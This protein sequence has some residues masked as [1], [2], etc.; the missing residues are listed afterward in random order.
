LVTDLLLRGE[1]LD[2]VWLESVKAHDFARNAKFRHIAESILIMQRFVQNV[3]GQNGGSTAV[4]EDERAFEARLLENPAPTKLCWYWILRLRA[5]F[6]FGDYA[7]AIAAGQQARAL[8]WASEGHIQLLDYCF[9]TALSAAAY[10]KEAPPDK[11]SELRE[12]LIQHLAQLKEWAENCPSTFRD[13]Y[14]LAAAEFARIKGRDL[15]AMRLY[16]EAIQSAHE[17]GFIHNEGIACEIAAKFCLQQGFNSIAN[18]YVRQARSCYLRWGA[19]SKVK[20]LDQLYPGLKELEPPGPTITI[21]ASIEQLDLATVVKAMQAVS[22]EI[23]LGKLIET[24]MVIA[25]QCAG[26]ERGLLFL[27]HG[28]EYR[29]V[30]EATTRDDKVQVN[31]AQTFLTLPKFPESI[32][33]Y[34]IRTRERVILD[35]ASA[36]SSF[37]HDEYIRVGRLRSILCLP[38]VKMSALIGVVYLENNLTPRAFTPGRLAVLELLASQAAI[39]LENARLY[40]ALCAS[41]ERMSLAAEGAKLALWEWDVVKDEIWMTDKGRALFGIGPDE[42]L[43]YAALMA[44]V[45]PEDRGTRDDAIRHALEPHGEYSMEY[46]VVLPDGQVR[47]MTGLGRYELGDGKPLRMRGVSFDITERKQAELEAAQQRRDLAHAARLTMAGELTASIA[48]E[49]GQPLGAILSNAEAAEILL[50]SE[51]PRPEQLRQILADIRNDD[52]RASEVIQRMRKLLRKRELELKPVDLNAAALDVLGFVAGEAQ[53]KGVKIERQFAEDLPFVRGD[54]IHLQQ[55][56]L[57]LILN[58]IEAMSESSASNRQLT[59]RTACDG[60]GNVEVAVEDSGPGIPPDR[61]PRLFES[62]FTTKRH[63]MGLGLSIVRSIVEA[64]GGRIWAQN[65]L[66]GGAC[67]RFRQPAL[68]QSA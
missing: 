41:E 27:T 52:L 17:N 68:E 58:G 7:A 20:Q 25:V 66:R 38:L 2:Q 21:G 43:N 13:K 32:L 16:E 11:Q 63:G 53:R 59:I 40:E 46:R 26:A 61:L 14:A 49:L 45:H 39:S 24:L 8:L 44:R 15:K 65:N 28:Q 35:D 29:T 19:H 57:N 37:S 22:R 54:V 62:F 5:H 60:E 47:W 33:R 31:F 50:E 36:E 64:H 51:P 18:S 12:L 30:A 6:M 34:V 10:W 56:L 55:V 4:A 1:H 42:Q 3:R 67:F 23:E 9:Y 48:H